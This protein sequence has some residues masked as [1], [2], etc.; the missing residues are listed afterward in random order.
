MKETIAKSAEEYAEWC[1]RHQHHN[2]YWTGVGTPQEALVLEGKHSSIRIPKAVHRPG[3][4]VPS[5]YAKTGRMF[6][7]AI[8]PLGPPSEAG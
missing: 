2:G 5:D 4:I 8:L 3:A 6:D 7:P 1:R